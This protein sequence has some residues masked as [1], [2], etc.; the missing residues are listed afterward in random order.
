VHLHFRKI[1]RGPAWERWLIVED[2]RGD[3]AFAGE[4][5]L[6]YS[7]ESA[8]AEVECD[9]LFARDLESDEMEELLEAASSILSGRGNVTVYTAREVTCQGF[10]LLEENGEASPN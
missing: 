2:Q 1:G 4:A 3:S 10:S 6:T 9:I 5:V 7:D 8:Y